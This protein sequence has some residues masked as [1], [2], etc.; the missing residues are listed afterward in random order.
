MFSDSQFSFHVQARQQ[1]PAQASE[2]AQTRNQQVFTDEIYYR[3]AHIGTK[4]QS[5]SISVSLSELIS[6]CVGAN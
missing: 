6:Q 5:H 3:D 4:V 2:K 1:Q